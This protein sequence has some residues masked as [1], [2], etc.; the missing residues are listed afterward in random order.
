MSFKL[1]WERWRELTRFRLACEMALSSYRKSFLE[2]P[3]RG[4][5]DAKIYDER[6]VTRFECS[7]NDFLDVLK[8]ETQLYRLLIVGHTSLI[9]EFGRVIVTQLLD[10]NLVGR[11]AFPGMQLHGTNAEATDHYIRKVNIE[12]WGSALLNAAKVTWDIVPGGQGAVVHAVVVRNIVGH[13]ANSY[14]NTAINR[15]NGVVPGYVTF[16]GGHSLILDREAFQQFLSTLRN[17]G[18]I[19][20]GVPARV[21]RNA[22]ERAS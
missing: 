4:I 15:I 6:G 5:Q 16:S 18:R 22:G 3:V 13:G 10:E 7:Y 11:V 21:R 19:I 8:D 1:V 17:F 9:E 2:L 14:N 12:A 20:C